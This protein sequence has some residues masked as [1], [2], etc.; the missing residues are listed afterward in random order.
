MTKSQSIPEIEFSN[1]LNMP[2]CALLIQ[3]RKRVLRP[4]V[5]G[6]TRTMLEMLNINTI[7]EVV[8]FAPGT[9]GT[10]KEVLSNPVEIY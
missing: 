1:P 10:A 3:M 7:D 2:I 4:G 8:E 6:L 9:S 5:M